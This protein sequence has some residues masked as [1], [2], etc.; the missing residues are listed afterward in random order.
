MDF[1]VSDELELFQAFPAGS[2]NGSL[3]LTVMTL[4]DFAIENPELLVVRVN[5]EDEAALITVSNTTITI[6]DG[7][8]GKEPKLH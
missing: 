5:S 4:N 2:S 8:T 1:N 6:L 7:S 3:C